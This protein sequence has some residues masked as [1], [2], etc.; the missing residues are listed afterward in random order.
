MKRKIELLAPAGSYE[1]LQAAIKNSADAIY[2]GINQLNMRAVSAANFTTC[3]LREITKICKKNKVKSYLTLNTVLYDNDLLLMKKII[4]SAKDNKVNALIISD[5]AAMQYTRSINMEV[6]ISTQL[7]ISNIEA[8]KFYSQFTDRII[9]ARELNLD[10]IEYIIKEIKRQKIK[11]P[12]GKLIEIEIFIHGALCIAISG[13][14]SMSLFQYN[15]SANRGACR[16]LCR[17]KYRISDYET[18]QELVIDN[19]YVMSP[20][21]ICT[22]GFLDKIISLGVKSLKI[23]GRG[24]SP[25]YVATVVKNYKKAITLIEKNKYTLKEKEKLEKNL[26]TVF[27]RGLSDGYYLGKKLHEWSAS[28]NSQ[29]TEEKIFTGIVK[30]YYSKIKVA[31]ILLQAYNIKVGDKYSITGKNTGVIFGKIK[32]LKSDDKKNIKKAAKG[33]LITIP[34][35]ERVREND[36]FYIIKKK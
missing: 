9:L 14:C 19:D 10:R 33:N 8:V 32:I 16:Q 12:K 27:N 30:H 25:E 17:R 23:E 6:H 22:I 31:E 7:S 15:S 26:K 24:R 5:V 2:F 20:T 28:G 4:D 11:G 13:R 34:I 18:N 3:D 1:S 21:D 35:K 29:A 36:K